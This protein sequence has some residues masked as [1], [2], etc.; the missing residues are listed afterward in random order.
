[1]A[2]NRRLLKDFVVRDLKAR[3]VGSSMGFFWSVIFPIIN[4]IVYMFVFR[5]VL[6]ARWSDFQ[7]PIEVALVMLAGIVVWAAFAE[8]ISRS[9]NTLVENANLIQKVVFPSEVLPLYLTI[10][11]LVNMLIG[12]P[13]V[14]LCVLYF[15]YAS[16]PDAVILQPTEIVEIEGRRSERLV[17]V[18]IDERQDGPARIG[19]SISRGWYEP[20]VVPVE[21]AGTAV[22]GVD[23]HCDLNEVRYPSGMLRV[24][25]CFWPI[26]DTEQEVPETIIIRLG[27][28]EVAGLGGLT[29]LTLTMIDAAPL[30]PGEEPLAHGASFIAGDTDPTYHPLEM[31]FSV[32]F[33]P[34]L[35][36]LQLIFTVG[37]GYFLSA[38]N[39]FLRDTY[40]LVGVGITVW[41]FGT[42]IFY[43]GTMVEK[44]GYGL[45]LAVNPMHWLIEGYRDVLLYGL[46][47]DFWM[48]GRLFVVG[49]MVLFLGSRFFTAQ[50]SKFPDLL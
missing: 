10:S 14:V 16:P 18:Q 43:P 41:M 4:L 39:L 31:G 42:P 29:E 11:S 24:E 33:V 21:F 15:A 23:Y 26:A 19:V 46:W 47:P 12:F 44:E 37:L 32:I 25:M 17:D 38:L 35:I 34:V 36:L 6:K 9:T 48:M 13:V 2:G 30:Q 7:G 28:P 1:M 27:T 40:H 49:V 22:R 45:M 8:T 5:I 50:K 3:Y 20:I